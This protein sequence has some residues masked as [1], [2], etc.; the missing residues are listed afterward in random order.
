MQLYD[1]YIEWFNEQGRLGKIAYHQN[2]IDTQAPE[3]QIEIP[4]PPDFVPHPDPRH[5][6]PET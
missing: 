2:L 3:T 1:W 5:R 4:L 6:T